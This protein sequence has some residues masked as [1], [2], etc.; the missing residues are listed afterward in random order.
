[1]DTVKQ[2]LVSNL[3]YILVSQNV[4]TQKEEQKWE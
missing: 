2:K 4:P 1:M 3:Q